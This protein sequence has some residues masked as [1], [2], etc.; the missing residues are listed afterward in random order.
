LER[1]NEARPVWEFLSFAPSQTVGGYLY[2]AFA[3]VMCVFAPPGRARNCVI[4]FAAMAL[5]V[6]TFQIRGVSFA[7][8][9]ALPGLAA[10]LTYRLLPRSIVWL[11]T[12]ILL[13]NGGAFTLA[14]V[15]L[16]G[17]DQVEKR[18]TAFKR[19]EDCAS[20]SALALLGAQPTGNV[21]AFVDQGPA[22][23]AYTRHAAI[24]GP[25]H[26]NQTGI[27]DTF[28][29]F[30]GAN[31]QAVLKQRGIDYLMTCRAAPDW[32][33]YRQRGGLVAQLATGQVPTWLVP[34]GKRGDV[35]LYRVSR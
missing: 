3:L 32:D 8:L 11:A 21:A 10:A 7:I 2:A 31:A 20:P 25:Y 17:Q 6:A 22:V 33:F 12:A 16:E 13:G 18:V 29:I 4:A 24:A 28:D 5:A 1:I 30:T 19:Q 26:R 9:F 34:I 27:L 15:M 23:L 14:G 35:E